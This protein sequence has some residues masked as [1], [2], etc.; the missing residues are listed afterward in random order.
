[1][2][3]LTQ[4]PKHMKTATTSSLGL[5][6]NKFQFKQTQYTKTHAYKISGD[7]HITK[8]HFTLQQACSAIVTTMLT[9]TFI[10][11]VDVCICDS[12][13][14]FQKHSYFIN[15]RGGANWQ[16]LL[17]LTG[18]ELGSSRTPF[19]FQAILS[20]CCHTDPVCSWRFPTEVKGSFL[21]ES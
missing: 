5:H 16:Q 19:G 6:T 3:I 9:Q 18:N 10:I 7:I 1:M 17:A 12:L 13:T 11:H 4:L 21:Y 20:Q 8:R 14:D 2:K 15:G